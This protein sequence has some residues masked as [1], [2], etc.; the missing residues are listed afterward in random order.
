MSH[1]QVQFMGSNFDPYW[2]PRERNWTPP[3]WKDKVPPPLPPSPPSPL[4]MSHHQMPWT[5]CP[6]C[7]EYPEALY[8]DC[9]EAHMLR[10]YNDAVS[11]VP[12]NLVPITYPY[13]NRIVT[14]DVHPTDQKKTVLKGASKVVD[15][16]T[17]RNLLKRWSGHILVT[18]WYIGTS[19]ILQVIEGPKPVPLNK[20]EMKVRFTSIFVKCLGLS[21]IMNLFKCVLY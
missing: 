9:R 7:R 5:T 2:G 11:G 6:E 18:T 8:I 10:K 19:S 20:T 4:D 17:L 16:S 15:N 12:V 14:A 21:L 3:G 1:M 13:P